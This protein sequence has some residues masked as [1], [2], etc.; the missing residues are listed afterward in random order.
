MTIQALDPRALAPRTLADVFW[1]AADQSGAGIWLRNVVLAL[2]GSI[3]VAATAQVYIPLEYVP[4]TGQTF[5]VLVIGLVYGMRLGAAT[6]ALYMLEGA[7]GLPVFGNFMSGMAVLKGTTGGYI[8]GF[9]FAAGLVGWLAE[10]GWSRNVLT[11]VAAM[12]IGNV[13]IYAFGLAWLTYFFSTVAAG[14]V[15]AANSTPFEFALLKGF[16]SYWPGDIVKIIAAALVLPTAWKIVRPM[17]GG[18]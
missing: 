14:A 9:I 6:L 11:T 10:K 17:R 15:A 5:G 2:V 3:F 8:V 4:I 7:I 13:V 1:P 16:V 18:L 12:V